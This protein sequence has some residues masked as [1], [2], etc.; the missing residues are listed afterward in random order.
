MN[1]LWLLVPGMLNDDRVWEDV[2]TGLQGH[3]QVRI[4]QVQKQ[5]SMLDMARDAWALLDDVAVNVPVYLAG[6][7]MGGYVAMEMLAQPMRPLKG[8]ALL[9]TAGGGETA[10]SRVQREKTIRALESDFAKTLEGLL[11]W[12]THEP[13]PELLA[14][15][16]TMMQ[17][18]GAETAV[19]QIRAISARR[20]HRKV[21][22]QLQMPVQLLC[23]EH[24]RVVPPARLQELADWIPGAFL[25]V[26]P[27]AGHM[28]P[29]EQPQTVVKT[30]LALMNH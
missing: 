20:E 24:D 19:R 28:L 16:R 2:A 14:R 17:D 3:A 8:L 1:A 25:E 29:L 6:F 26:V 9:D 11:K 7:S 22:E 15:L 12:N 5:T 13:S 4:A 10:E 18:V 21:L 27:G 30:L 23:G